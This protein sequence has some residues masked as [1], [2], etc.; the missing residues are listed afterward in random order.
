MPFDPSSRKTVSCKE[1]DDAFRQNP[2]P[3]GKTMQAFANKLGLNKKQVSNFFERERRKA[4]VVLSSNSLASTKRPDATSGNSKGH[5]GTVFKKRANS[6]DALYRGSVSSNNSRQSNLALS[7]APSGERVGITTR[8]RRPAIASGYNE[9]DEEEDEQASEDEHERDDHD[10]EQSE[11]DDVDM[12]DASIDA[13]TPRP[14]TAAS[15]STDRPATRAGSRY[16]ISRMTYGQSVSPFS[17]VRNRSYPS[18]MSPFARKSRDESPLRSIGIPASGNKQTEV[19]VLTFSSSSPARIDAQRVFH[20][21]P[22][23]R[24]RSIESPTIQFLKNPFP[25]P[26]SCSWDETEEA[27]Y[28]H[29][30]PYSVEHVRKRARVWFSRPSTPG[31]LGEPDALYSKSQSYDSSNRSSRQTESSPASAIAQLTE[32]KFEKIHHFASQTISTADPATRSVAAASSSVAEE[33]DDLSESESEYDADEAAALKKKR[34]AAALRTTIACDELRQAFLANPHPPTS[35]LDALATKLGLGKKQVSN[36]FVRERKKAGYQIKVRHGLNRKR[37]PRKPK[38]AEASIEPGSVPASFAVPVDAEHPE[39]EDE[40]D[41]YEMDDVASPMDLDD[42]ETLSQASANDADPDSS[43]FPNIV[44][45]TA[46]DDGRDDVPELS[47]DDVASIRSENPVN[48]DS[49]SS[50]MMLASNSQ[51]SVRTTTSISAVQQ[52]QDD[53]EEPEELPS[54]LF[55]VTPLLPAYA[56]AESR[57]AGIYQ[58]GQPII[59]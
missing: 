24:Y 44:I 17:N 41:E 37:G 54:P 21:Y 38:K 19:P 9:E 20:Y 30:S 16:S 25:D 52:V 5:S 12:E 48:S 34:A 49:I 27:A 18:S 14:S 45:N 15:D 26:I 57:K 58:P 10:E 32:E 53:D 11:S 7:V 36:Y 31:F 8:P 46:S 43:L 55:L 22:R 47:Y 6:P 40:E 59:A 33:N 23:R 1:L 50:L 39:P 4:G 3:D 56:T 13:G 29:F 35:T 51:D 42:D 28:Y 2:H